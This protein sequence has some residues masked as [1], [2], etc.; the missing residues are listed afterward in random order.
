MNLACLLLYASCGNR[1]GR[2]RL[3]VVFAITDMPPFQKGLIWLFLA[4][5]AEVPPVVGET[6]SVDPIPLLIASQVFMSL[7][8]NGIAFF[9]SSLPQW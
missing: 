8:L 1:W 7:N 3:S 9:F 6:H 5:I 2:P 4:T